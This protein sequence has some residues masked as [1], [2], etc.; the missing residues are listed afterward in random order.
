MSITQTCEWF[1][2]GFSLVCHSETTGSAGNL[3]TLTVL[4]YNSEEKIY[5]FYELNSMGLNN[6]AN[7][8]V[9]GDTWTFNAESKM[10]GKLVKTRFTI[11][12]PSPDT[13]LMKSEVSVDGSP[14]TEIMELK[15]SRVK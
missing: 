1:T 8:S 9:E 15:G 7:G 5:T 14:W 10:G 11:K 2:G 6:L 12:M 4:N 3:K 13:A